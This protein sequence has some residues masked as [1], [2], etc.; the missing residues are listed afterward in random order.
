MKKDF[1]KSVM[2][3]QTLCFYINAN[4]VR[5]SFRNFKKAIS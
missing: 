3:Y 5:V 2:A 4:I 1:S